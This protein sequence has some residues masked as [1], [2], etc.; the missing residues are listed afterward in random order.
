MAMEVAAG[1]RRA[2]YLPRPVPTHTPASAASA[3]LVAVTDRLRHQGRLRR[4]SQGDTTDVA[5]L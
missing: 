1:G 4:P 5:Q 3:A 2:D